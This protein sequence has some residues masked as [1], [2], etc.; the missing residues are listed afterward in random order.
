[1]K[2]ISVLVGFGDFYVMT[3]TAMCFD[4]PAKS[5]LIFEGTHQKH[6]KPTKTEMLTAIPTKS[7][8]HKN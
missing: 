8:T 1:M 5:T 2:N 7:T 4:E 3:K 6:I